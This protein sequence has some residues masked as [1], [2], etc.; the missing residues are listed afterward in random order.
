[1]ERITPELLQKY[2]QGKC[3]PEENDLVNTWY[4]SF[5]TSAD[6]IR[7]LD[8]QQHELLRKKMM[9]QI[10]N[11]LNEADQFPEDEKKQDNDNSTGWLFFKV[12]AAISVLAV[13]GIGILYKDRKAADA[14][15]NLQATIATVVNKTQSIL[16]Q[17]LSD[18]TTV[19]LKPSSSIEYPTIFS[20][21]SRVI[22]LKG[23]A[24]FDVAREESRPFIVTTGN[25]TTKVLGTSFNIKAY[26]DASTIEVSVMTGKVAVQMKPTDTRD[27]SSVLLTPNER[28]TYVKSENRLLK[29]APVQLPELSMWQVTTIVYENVPVDRV[30]RMLEEKYNVTIHVKNENLK[31]CLLRADFTNQNLADILEMVS[32]SIEATYELK[33]NTIYLDG[34]GCVKEDTTTKSN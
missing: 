32:R 31:N 34:T 27:S 29:E 17:D 33:D 8:I 20:K 28:V 13:I 7:L 1:M 16:R 5:D 15:A 21:A 18:G 10:K 24:F 2:L 26:H 11:N 14:P 22:Q 30:L 9:Q 25:V 23:E 4:D 6:D 3:T 19:W 12:A